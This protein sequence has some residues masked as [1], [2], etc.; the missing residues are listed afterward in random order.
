MIFNEDNRLKAKVIGITIY[1]DIAQQN[2]NFI[3]TS[4]RFTVYQLIAQLGQ[5]Q[6][7]FAVFEL[8]HSFI[9]EKQNSTEAVFY[10]VFL[11]NTGE[12]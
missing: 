11:C 4:N 8:F 7:K 6:M 1:I 2:S 9:P 12:T 3:I 5:N 10:F